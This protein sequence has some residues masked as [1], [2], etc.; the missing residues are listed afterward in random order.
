[1]SYRFERAS[2]QGARLLHLIQVKANSFC[3][4]IMTS[5]I[6]SGEEYATYD[7]F[8]CQRHCL[9]LRRVRRSIGLERASNQALAAERSIRSREQVE[10]RKAANGLDC[11]P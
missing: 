1:M 6:T 2:S 8:G 10:S 7:D 11:A 5:R 3:R 9:G 4:V